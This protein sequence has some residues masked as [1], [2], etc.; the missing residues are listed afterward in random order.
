MASTPVQV[1]SCGM[2]H[3]PSS[4]DRLNHDCFCVTLDQ[5]EVEAALLRET[6]LPHIGEIMR[7]ERRHLFSNLSVF[8]SDQSFEQMRRVVEAIQAVTSLPG[9]LES[10]MSWAPDVA[11]PNYGPL[12][13]FMG[14]DFHVGPDGPKLIEINTNAGGALL[15]AVLAQ[16]QR[17]CCGSA[18]PVREVF[19]DVGFEQAVVRMFEEEW[20]L[21]RGHGKPQ[22]IA[23]V[24]NDPESQYLYPEFVLARSIFERHGIDAV[25]ADPSHL[26]HRQGRLTHQGRT[27]DL[28]YNRL[29]DFP[30]SEP[31]HS[32]LRSAY[33]TGSVVVTP[34]PHVH[35]RFA[36]KRNLTL[37][38]DPLRLA[39]FGA[40]APH[41]ELLGR[42]VP[43]SVL[44]TPANADELWA[45]RRGLFFKPVTGYGSKA[46][47]RGAKITRTVWSEIVEGSHIAQAFIP[48]SQRMVKIDDKRELRK[49]D[50]RLYSYGD[51]ILL[52]AARLYQGQAT[53]FRTEGGGFAPVLRT[54]AKGA[55]L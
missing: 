5:T 42:V 45:A 14:Y 31:R 6:N 38:C 49:M 33:M 21:Q 50:V 44:V 11:Q 8:I 40:S 28:V 39:A 23:I 4:T 19:P 3:D 1:H 2:S 7:A 34:N 43:N 55:S 18:P 24:D 26:E 37:L 48:P 20:R 13:A 35:A 53:N 54:S 10:V 29:V 32:G 30:L 22:R 52:A 36:D 9:Y 12:G 41:V 27:I 46:V 17:S 25:I 51:K 47:Y 15:N 16:A